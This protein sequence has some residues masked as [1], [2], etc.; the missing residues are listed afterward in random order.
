MSEGEVDPRPPTSEGTVQAIL[1]E[2]LDEKDYRIFKA[3][4]DDGRMSDTEL[5]ERVDLSRTAARRRRK[6]LQNEGIMDILA[7]IV[8]QEAD[9]AYAD[10][11]VTLDKHV[12]QA[13]RTALIAKLLDEELIYSIDSCLGDYDLFVRVWNTSLDDVKNYLWELFE[14]EEAVAEYRTTPVVK[15][16]KAWDKELDRPDTE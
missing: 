1:E 12:T 3:L 5:A 11:R 13:E 16:W 9:L 6:K 10:V 7:V 2:Y 8:L 14:Q 15:T 4:N